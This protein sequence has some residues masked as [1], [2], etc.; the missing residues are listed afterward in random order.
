MT[1]DSA[2]IGHELHPIRLHVQIQSHR[3]LLPSLQGSTLTEILSLS[4]RVHASSLQGSTL[5][6]ILSLSQKVHA[7]SLQGSTLTEILSLSQMVLLSSLQGSILT[8]I[9]CFSHKICMCPNCRAP[10]SLKVS[11]S[12]MQGASVLTVGLLLH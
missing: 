3:M 6:E 2:Q 5:T 9:I 7:P 11:V 12:V 4:L 1:F 10:A 8:E